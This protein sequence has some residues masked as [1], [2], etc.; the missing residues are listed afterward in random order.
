[1]PH[2]I[3]SKCMRDCEPYAASWLD[4]AGRRGQGGISIKNL[5]LWQ[6]YGLPRLSFR[7]LCLL[8]VAALQALAPFIQ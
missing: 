2:E 1:M 7:I 4:L 6:K 8:I 3:G 5:E